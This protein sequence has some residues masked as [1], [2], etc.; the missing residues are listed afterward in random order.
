MMTW[1]SFTSVLQDRNEGYAGSARRS[2][3]VHEN[4]DPRLHHLL[5][6]IP[7]AD[8]DEMLSRTHLEPPPPVVGVMK[9]RS[10]LRWA[11]EARQALSSTGS[12]AVLSLPPAEAL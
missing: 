5:L 10:A 6:E 1:L 4:G 9:K 2:E 7:L 3:K 12:A 11:S 8:F